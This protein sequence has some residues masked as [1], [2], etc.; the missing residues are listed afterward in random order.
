MLVTGFETLIFA[1]ITCGTP[2]PVNM[3]AS[4]A[5]AQYGIKQNQPFVIGA[6]SGLSLVIIVT[7]CGIG[8]LLTTNVYLANLM[9]LTGSAYLLYLAFVL[10]RSKTEI[11]PSSIELNLPS[12]YQGAILQMIN[13]KAWL[14]SMAGI[15]M[16]LDSSDYV[17]S[18][19]MYV[20][21]FY[22]ACYIAVFS[23]VYLGQLAASKL[24][25]N[26][27][28]AFNRLLAGTLALLVLFNLYET[29]SPYL[30]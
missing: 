4:M 7:G 20:T 5:G 12:F 18:L 10:M 24:T 8:Q 27:L 14:V 17:A 28:S 11:D 15:S 1:L 3:I 23:W 25:D 19:V 21:I 22:L 9:T 13:P 16:F 26:Y 30:L 29:F 2:G 6:T